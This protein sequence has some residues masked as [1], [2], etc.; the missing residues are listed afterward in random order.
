MKDKGLIMV[1]LILGL[2]GSAFAAGPSS[3]GRLPE[4]TEES[5]LA[6]YLRYAELNNPRL[7]AA[8]NRWQAELQ[9]ALQAGVLPDPKFSYG[10][11]IQEVET[12]VGPQRQKFRLAQSFPWPGKLD[13][14]EEMAKAA[15]KAA[16]QRYVAEKLKVF[17]EVKAAYYEYYYLA[18]AIAITEE[19]VRLMEFFENVARTKYKVG[20]ATHA[21]II[22]AQVELGELEDRLRSL[23]DLRRPIVA[24]L[25]AALDRPVDAPLPW[26]KAVPKETVSF[27]DAEVL[28]WLKENNPELKA[29]DAL[30]ERVD[31][32]VRFAEMESLPDFTL[33]VEYVDVGDAW[34]MGVD[35]SGK[36][37]VAVMVTIN[38]PVWRKKYQ[39]AEEEARIR[40]HAVKRRRKAEEN[41]LVAR[42]KQVVYDFRD[43]ERKIDLY[44][45]TLVPKAE[46]ALQVTQQAFVAGKADFL[47]LIEAQRT[48]LEFKLAYERALVDRAQKLAELEMLVGQEIPRKEG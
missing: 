8:Y 18:R 10:Y 32:A 12:R 22:K 38:L 29:I 27:A 26:P 35:D 21:D 36:D 14:Q 48:L 44:R 3:G 2:W 33:G 40:L 25:N 30:T 5:G 13:L 20:V 45:D 11:F 4:L 6:D 37:A 42:V 19:N 46:Q 31:A 43:A 24:R 34:M 39:A 23:R 28:E 16:R 9:Q 1:W 15:A 7:E 17:Y 41:R 47:D